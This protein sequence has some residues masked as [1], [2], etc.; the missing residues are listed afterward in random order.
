MAEAFPQ[1]ERDSLVRRAREHW[2]RMYPASGPKPDAATFTRT[3]ERY[4]QALAEY[5]DRLPRVVLGVCPF[6][7]EPLRRAFDPFGVDGWWWHV[8][9]VIAVEE[10]RAPAAFQLLM[11][12]YTLGRPEPS[13]AR[14][15]VKP[16]PDVPCV[17]P[18]LLA[19]PGMRAVVGRVPLP[20]G[21]VAWPI[22]YWSTEEIHPVDLHQPWLRDTYWFTDDAGKSGWSIANDVWDF[23]LKKWVD[24]GQLFW[25]DLEA[26]VPVIAADPAPLLAERSGTRQP[27]LLAD[28][29]RQFLPLPDGARVVPF[30]EADDPETTRLT[31][32]ELAALEGDDDRIG[33]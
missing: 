2:A 30:G 32:A 21:D 8:D 17:I 11:G 1:E 13:E 26:E 12:A 29:R 31:P 3:R 20:S 18:A 7:G 16:G 9:C 25:A 33:E 27:Q 19:L 23:D 14:N 22:S 5:S 4:Y 24:A 15:P 28:G 10:P 6:T